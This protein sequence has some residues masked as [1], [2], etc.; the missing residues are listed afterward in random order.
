MYHVRIS[1]IISEPC[2]MRRDSAPPEADKLLPFPDSAGRRLRRALAALDTAL[3]G[4]REAVAG[5]RHQL[6]QLN[7]ALRNLDNSASALRDRLGQAATEAARA[8]RSS[9][10]LMLTARAWESMARH[11]EGNPAAH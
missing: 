2:M 5:L 9:R 6:G 11:A 8:G 3:A 4:Q 10:E 1:L 7:D